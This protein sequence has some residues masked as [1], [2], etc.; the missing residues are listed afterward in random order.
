MNFKELSYDTAIAG[1]FG[2][3]IANEWSKWKEYETNRKNQFS[4]EIDEDV[5]SITNEIHDKGYVVI[6]DFFD[7]K[8]LN[9]LNEE[10]Q[11]YIK[12][13]KYQKDMAGSGVGAESE[14]RDTCLWTTIDQPLYNVNSLFNIAFHDDL[15]TLASHYFGCLPYFGT[16]NLRNS[17]VNGLKEDHKIGRE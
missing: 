15:I 10:T 11:N 2:S 5:L 14:I 13:G 9:E 16:L 3:K 1:Q 17:F 4:I 7:V 12:N 6:K 8:M